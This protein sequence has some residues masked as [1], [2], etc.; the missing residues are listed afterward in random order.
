[1]N[2]EGDIR[3]GEL[4]PIL[5]KLKQYRSMSLEWPLHNALWGFEGIKEL[6]VDLGLTK[7]AVV[8]LCRMG[9]A[10]ERNPQV[11]V[12]KRLRF[13]SDSEAFVDHCESTRRVSAQSVRRLAKLI[14]QVQ[15]FTT[16]SWRV[17]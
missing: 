1:M 12:C 16:T 3:F 7:E 15:R 6:L 10:R 13:V 14:G 9:V 11:L 8:R 4:E 17:C 2:D 5:G